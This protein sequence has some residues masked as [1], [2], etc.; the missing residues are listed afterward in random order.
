MFVFYYLV[1]PE[2][3]NMYGLIREVDIDGSGQKRGAIIVLHSK[4]FA[5]LMPKGLTDLI[6]LEIFFVHCTCSPTMLSQIDKSFSSDN[7]K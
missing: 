4:I 5:V 7:L 6:L 1:A 2:I 3:Q